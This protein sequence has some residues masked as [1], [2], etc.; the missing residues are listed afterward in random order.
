M[1]IEDPDQV[2]LL[3]GWEVHGHVRDRARPHVGP[4]ALAQEHLAPRLHPASEEHHPGVAGVGHVHAAVGL[5]V[6][7]PDRDQAG[8]GDGG[9]ALGD[10]LGDL[11]T[12]LTQESQGGQQREGGQPCHSIHRLPT[13]SVLVLPLLNS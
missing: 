11:Q 5:P 13:L 1:G 8:G 3:A 4:R 10:A 12:A 2:R 6:L 9:G 7:D